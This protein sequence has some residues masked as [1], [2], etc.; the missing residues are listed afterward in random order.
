MEAGAQP[1]PAPGRSRCLTEE[2]AEDAPYVMTAAPQDRSGREHLEAG[3]RNRTVDGFGDG[4]RMC[5]VV[6][7]GEHEDIAREGAQV[8]GCLFG[9]RDSDFEGES[10]SCLLYTSDAAD[11]LQPV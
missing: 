3:I 4:D 10:E 2:L 9:I 7:V 5:W 11:D 1:K 8:P 6:F